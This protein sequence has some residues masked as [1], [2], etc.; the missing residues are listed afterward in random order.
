V[1]SPCV[2][3]CAN[4]SGLG[5]A[6]TN[7]LVGPGT[8][9][10]RNADTTFLH[11]NVAFAPK[12]TKVRDIGFVTGKE[13][14]GGLLEETMQIEP[15]YGMASCVHSFRPKPLERLELSKHRPRHV[16]KR[17]VLPLYHTVLMWCVGSG[18]L[19]LDTFLLKILLNLLVLELGPIVAPYL[20]H[21]ELKFVLSPS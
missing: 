20:F 15:V 17:P 18:E 3:S 9:R 14:V 1:L 5:R 13:F 19:M 4:P 10:G 21:L 7:L 2:P 12:Y 6:A 8:P 16:D 11:Q